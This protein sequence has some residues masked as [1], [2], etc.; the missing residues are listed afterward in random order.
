M[1][2]GSSGARTH[3]K[4]GS[5]GKATGGGKG[6]K[7]AKSNGAL[8][9][10]VPKKPAARREEARPKPAA[11]KPGLAGGKAAARK[12]SPAVKA[13]GV[14]HD[15]PLAASVARETP[16]RLKPVVGKANGTR[17]PS[18]EEMLRGGDRREISVATEAAAIARNDPALV[19]K[20][21]GWLLA[22]DAILRSRAAW[23][24]KEISKTNPE[25]LQP[26]KKRFLSDVARIDQ[27][28]VQ[29]QLC[30]I[31]PRLRLTVP[32]LSRAVRIA[33]AC[34]AHPS[35]IVRSS[36]LQALSEL[37]DQDP[38]VQPQ[39]LTL[40]RQALLDGSPA[41]QARAQKIVERLSGGRNGV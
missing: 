35:G 1:V 5:N 29:E 40:L 39:V 4:P 10:E 37:A 22:K 31:L 33:Y 9:R 23:A 2:G 27:W 18:L 36:G 21:V 6:A 16:G 14:R 32:E 11:K 17:K 28:E 15:E 38:E 25:R 34:L 26:H 19:E 41:M 12:S 3:S 30:K 20:L 13:N 7:A 24:L 8:K